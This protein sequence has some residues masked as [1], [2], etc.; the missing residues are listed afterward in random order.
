LTTFTDD[1]SGEPYKMWVM[2]N[3]EIANLSDHPEPKGKI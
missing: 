2:P 3:G 1:E